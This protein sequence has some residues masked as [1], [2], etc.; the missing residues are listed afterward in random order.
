MV[1]LGKQIAAGLGKLRAAGVIHRDIKSENILL[2]RGVC[3]LG[4]FGFA[5]EENKLD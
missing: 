2:Q 3:K 5:I 4:D 1:A